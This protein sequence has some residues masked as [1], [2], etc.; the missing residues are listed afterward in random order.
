MKVVRLGLAALLAG[1]APAWAVDLSLEIVNESGLTI[2]E[3]Y[4][5]PAGE[6]LWGEDLLRARVLGRG[7]AIHVL[8][9]EGEPRCDY[10]LR[11]VLENGRDLDQ[12]ARVCEATTYTVRNP[13]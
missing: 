12:T 3:I 5:S 7:E 1:A 6:G 11:L 8:I 4:A 2:M 10:D 13:S 9:P